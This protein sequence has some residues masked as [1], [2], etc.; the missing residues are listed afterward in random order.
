MHH[1]ELGDRILDRLAK[2]L[3][4]IGTVEVASKLDGRNMTIMF[5]PVKK[6][7]AG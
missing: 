6:K 5:A 4:G 1:T 3:D 2:D 7:A